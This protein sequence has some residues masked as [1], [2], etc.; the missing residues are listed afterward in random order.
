MQSRGLTVDPLRC[1]TRT[2]K[3]AKA[4]DVAVGLASGRTLPGKG[5]HHVPKGT[6]VVILSPGDGGL[7]DLQPRLGLMLDPRRFVHGTLVPFGVE[8]GATPPVRNN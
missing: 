1:A 6:R 5:R 7:G 3:R 8:I 2:G 4:V